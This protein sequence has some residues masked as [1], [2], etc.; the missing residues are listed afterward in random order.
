[1]SSWRA[2][3]VRVQKLHERAGDLTRGSQH[4]AGLDVATPEDV[5]IPAGGRK[6]IPT[7]LKVAFPPG[8]Y[9][10]VAPRSGNALKKG[11]ETGAGVIDADYRGEL[12]VLLFNLSN[13]D[14][15][16]KANDKIAQLILER[17]PDELTVDYVNSLDETARGEGGFGSTDAKVPRLA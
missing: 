17:I 8:W 13:E 4:A 3:T 1:M 15:S 16:F 10:R 14:A 2:V 6:L 7:G 11:I 5:I 9:M 12:G